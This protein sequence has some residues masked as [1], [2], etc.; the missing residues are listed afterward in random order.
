M[1]TPA[2]TPDI[3]EFIRRND[4]SILAKYS[5]ENTEFRRSLLEAAEGSMAASKPGRT[6]LAV[7][8][9]GK[10]MAI[11]IL[12]PA[13]WDSKHFGLPVGRCNFISV[14]DSAGP[15]ALTE[16]LDG[17]RASALEAGWAVVYVRVPVDRMELVQGLETI[18]ARMADV[19]ITFRMGSMRENAASNGSLDSDIRL[20]IP[21]DETEVAKIAGESFVYDRFHADPGLSG[22]ADELYRVWALNQLREPA[23]AV[24]VAR[25]GGVTAGFVTCKVVAVGHFSY[26]VID[27]IAVSRPQRGRG[28]GSKLLRAAL[29]WFS[30]RTERVYVGTQASN[31]PALALYSDAGFSV[32]YV[33][34]TMHLWLGEGT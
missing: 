24:L 20:S 13:D 22:R 5:A 27:L 2:T 17:L 6:A 30:E 4:S 26:G 19:L 12:E 28:V 14:A 15:G 16:L 18:G 10:A 25:V 8:E 7:R 29:E 23:G 31:F 1:I 9:A 11:A 34:A 3:S 21:Q 32:R 33:E